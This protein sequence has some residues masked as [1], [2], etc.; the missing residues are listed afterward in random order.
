MTIQAPLKTN[1]SSLAERILY[2]LV[3]AYSEKNHIDNQTVSISTQ[4][5]FH[6]LMKNM[7]ETLYRNPAVL[8]IPLEYPDEP[9]LKGECLN[10][11]P[12]RT[13]RFKSIYNI[14]ASFYKF[15][16]AVG[17]NGQVIKDTLVVE[18]CMTKPKAKTIYLDYMKLLGFVIEKSKSQIVFSYPDVPDILK[19][20]KLLAEVSND[21]GKTTPWEN[22]T[23][24]N[25]VACVYDG[26]YMYWL[27]RSNEL[28]D[29]APGFLR[30][31]FQNYKEQGY[32]LMIYGSFSTNEFDMGCTAKKEVSGVTFLYRTREKDAYVYQ[33]SNFIGLKAILEQYDTLTEKMKKYLVDTCKLCNECLFCTKGKNN[34]VHAQA[35]NY[36]GQERRLCPYYPNM[37]WNNHDITND[38]VTLVKEFNELQENN[39]KDWRK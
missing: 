2:S 5:Q 26:D 17:L 9:F 34:K 22:G 32:S 38:I 24:F 39:G 25:F 13:K 28:L 7:L 8:N 31:V 20:W 10:Q 1:F 12:D 30:S 21:F 23:L 6:E 14:I 19:A 4:H 15:M 11:Y 16:Y 37:W 3:I 29:A 36:E 35:V 27:D 18:S 33:P